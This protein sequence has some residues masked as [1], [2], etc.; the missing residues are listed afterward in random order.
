MAGSGRS[1][2]IA[3][4]VLPLALACV[5]GGAQGSALVTRQLLHVSSCDSKG[6]Q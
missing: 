2:T 4:H 5:C 6:H 1:N 3:E